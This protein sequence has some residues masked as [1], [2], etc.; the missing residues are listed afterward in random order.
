MPSDYKIWW[1]DKI[2]PVI[3]EVARYQ[4]EFKGQTTEEYNENIL[5]PIYDEKSGKYNTPYNRF[6]PDIIYCILKENNIVNSYTNMNGVNRFDRTLYPH[7]WQGL[8]IDNYNWHKTFYYLP[9]NYFDVSKIVN[10][11]INWYVNVYS[12]A[13]YY[14]TYDVGPDSEQTG[15]KIMYHTIYPRYYFDYKYNVNNPPS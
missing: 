10:G 11:K 3:E 6:L 13:F 14:N 2:D 8:N 12:S 7:I 9:S 1:N 4:Q 5:M 15:K